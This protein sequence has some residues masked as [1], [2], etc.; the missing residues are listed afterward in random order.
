MSMISQRL[1]I[2]YHAKLVQKKRSG[3]H[4]YYALADDH[5][6]HLLENAFEQALKTQRWLWDVTSNVSNLKIS[7]VSLEILDIFVLSNSVSVTVISPVK[8][9]VT[10]SFKIFPS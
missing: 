2:L 9:W 3:K 7:V 6:V 4:I 1:K 5:I 8:S 10:V